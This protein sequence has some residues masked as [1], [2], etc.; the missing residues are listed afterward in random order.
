[1]C[2]TEERLRLDL[3]N[4]RAIIATLS[5]RYNLENVVGE[6]LG[7]AVA[8]ASLSDVTAAPPPLDVVKHRLDLA[9]YYLRNV[10]MYCYYCASSFDCK[11]E[12]NNRCGTFHVRRPLVEGRD[13]S[14][15]HPGA[16]RLLKA[17][18]SLP[19]KEEKGDLEVLRQF[20]HYSV[21]EYSLLFNT[22][23]IRVTNYK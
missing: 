19:T 4:T 2:S 7:D 5:K 20:N 9:V 3:K 6:F 18:D 17:L 16:Q 11:E 8:G 21:D 23:T 10:F 15:V 13:Y 12:L 22:V 1:M 14:T